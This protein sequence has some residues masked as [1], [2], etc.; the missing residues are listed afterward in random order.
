MI[1][2]DIEVGKFYKTTIKSIYTR[3]YLCVK[4]EEYSYRHVKVSWLVE[5][6]NI[7]KADYREIESISLKEV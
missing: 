2:K 1:V 4:K 3:I 5:E 6:G 7:I